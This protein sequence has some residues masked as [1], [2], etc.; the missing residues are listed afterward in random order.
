LACFG[1][2]VQVLLVWWW[3]ARGRLGMLTK[4]SK[5]LSAAEGDGEGD[6]RRGEERTDVVRGECQGS[7]VERE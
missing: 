3:E 2:D 6:S 7:E 1:F 4:E 5:V